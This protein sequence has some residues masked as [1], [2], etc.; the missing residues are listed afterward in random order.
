MRGSAAKQRRSPIIVANSVGRLS[1]TSQ[2][3]KNTR[4]IAAP[5][6]RDR[7]R[8]AAAHVK[9]EEF[10]RVLDLACAGLSCELLIR[11]EH[12]ADA[13]R[14]DRVT[15]ADEAAAR[16]YRNVEWHF[17]FFLTHLRQRRCAIFHKLH[18]FAG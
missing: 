7:S 11:F 16:V 6:H 13:R 10:S 17:G 1:Q 12:L 14:A 18:T 9:R 2:A 3:A 4:S 15:V 5:N 8:K